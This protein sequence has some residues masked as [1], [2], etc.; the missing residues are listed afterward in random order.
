MGLFSSKTIISVSSSLYNLAGEEE[1]REN[2]L[3][4]N[5]FSAHL[6]DDGSYLGETLVGNYLS[7]PGIKQRQFFSWAVRNDYVGLPALSVSNTSEIDPAIVA[8]FISVPPSPSGLVTEVFDASLSDGDYSY[9]AEQYVLAN[10]PE[11][12]DTEW[13]SEYNYDDHTITIQY[14]DGSTEIIPGGAYSS[15][16]RFIVGYYFQYVPQNTGPVVY[17]TLHTDVDDFSSLPDD[18]DYVQDFQTNTTT[19]TF[20]M[21]KRTTE[22]VTYSN[23]SNEDV[24]VTDEPFSDSFLGN[25]IVKT[26]SEFSGVEEGSSERSRTDYFYNIHERR[27]IKV[28][29]TTTVTTQEVNGVTETTTTVVE[30]DYLDPVWDYQINTQET[31]FDTVY[32]GNQIYIYELG[33]GNATL[34]ALESEAAVGT[35]PEF[36]PFIPVRINNKSIT[37]ETYENNGLY[38]E[39]EAAYKKASNRASFSELIESVE[40]NEDLNQ[41]D[42]AY[43]DFGVVLNT[44]SNSGKKYIHE[45]L[46][47]LIPYQNTTPQEMDDFKANVVSYNA[48]VAAYQSWHSRNQGQDA[49]GEEP[50]PRPSI[51]VP[52]TTTLRLLTDDS[53]TQSYDIRLSWSNIQEEIITGEHETSVAVGDTRL[54]KGTSISWGGYLFGSNTLHTIHVYRQLTA[55]TYSKITAYGLLH[56]N[57]I[58]GGKNVL[59]N[60]STALDDDEDSSFLVPMHQ[61]TIK[62]MSLVDTTQIATENTYLVIN[63]YTITKQEWYQRGIFKLILFI[64]IIV[65]SV[66]INPGAL[67]GATGLLGT[68]LAVGTAIGLSGT[69]AIIAGAAINAIVGLVVAQIITAGATKLFGAKLGAIIGAIVSFAIGFATTG[70]FANFT[71]GSAESILKLSNVLANAY[72]GW[73]AANIT[74]I[75]EQ[76]AE[77][78]TAYEN[79]LDEINDL[80]KE[81]GGT[82]DLSFNPLQLTDVTIGNDRSVSGYLPEGLDEFIQ[83]TTMVGSDIV[84][85]TLSMIND[86]PDLARQLPRN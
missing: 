18:T 25:T 10:F 64:V 59:T 81:L 20:S 17:G 82:N 38:D 63:S 22:T 50:P 52:K 3:K 57:Y 13:A 11:L 4:A 5:L 74:E 79:K 85:I 42:Y 53:L 51:S 21:N 78:Q 86:Y 41:I 80:L 65:V 48:A 30:L 77:N 56:R 66:L 12:Y 33:T 16:K 43:V 2:Y 14:E 34:D 47:G 28:N 73:T 8:P 83:R 27:Q 61:P 15:D 35:E 1:G 44:S 72:T 6:K 69:A 36:Y 67:A 32:G 70:G 58:Y 49:S 23:S 45:F 46:K 54:E 76:M 9:F 68:N 7:G 29:T 31:V 55:T 39:A 37:H 62:S 71:F 19:E 84:E 26:K 60:T 75:N 24:T 40:D